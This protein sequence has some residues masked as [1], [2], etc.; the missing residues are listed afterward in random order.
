MSACRLVRTL[1]VDGLACCVGCCIRL[2]TIPERDPSRS[3]W[4]PCVRSF[5]P[6]SSAWVTS[7]R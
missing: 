2:P 3:W 4:R 6:W 7:S 1:W 5:S